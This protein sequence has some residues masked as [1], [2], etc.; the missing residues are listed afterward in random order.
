M[1]FLGYS[2]VIPTK[3]EHIWILRFWVM[4]RTNRQT[5][6]LE[7]PDPN[8]CAA[9]WRVCFFV[10]KLDL[11][12]RVHWCVITNCGAYIRVSCANDCII[13]PRFLHTQRRCRRPSLQ[14]YSW[15]LALTTQLFME[16]PRSPLVSRKALPNNPDSVSPS[17]S[18]VRTDTIPGRKGTYML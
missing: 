15:R 16:A 11:I 8:E 2:K 12:C 1:S 3:F 9:M 4:L 6:R 18:N 7:H 13:I 14:S 10:S 5:D 17:P